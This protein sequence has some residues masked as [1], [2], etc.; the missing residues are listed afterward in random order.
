MVG[1]LASVEA[2]LVTKVS[3]F[4][5][6]AVWPPT[7]ARYPPL[8]FCSR[9]VNCVIV[10]LCVC[11]ETWLLMASMEGEVE[12]LS[13]SMATLGASNQRP[14]IKMVAFTQYNTV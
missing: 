7:L 13:Q 1:L 6:P 8:L 4:D 5:D 11:I 9:G 2:V 3:Y 14:D 12:K 10:R